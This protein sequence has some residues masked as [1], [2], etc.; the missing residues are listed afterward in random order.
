MKDITNNEM[1]FI[2]T[3]FKNPKT[4][5]NANN[6]SKVLGISSMGCLNIA[7]KLEKEKIISFRQLGKAKFFSIE[8][9]KDYVKDYISFLLKREAEQSIPY[10]RVW[11]NDLR[12]KITRAEIIILFGSVL[13]KWDNAN[14]ID[15]LLVTKQKDFEK[16]KK[17]VENINL[18]SNKKLH[19]VYQTL[20][21]LKE[22]IKKQ[23]PVILNIIRGIVVQGSEKLVE[24]MIKESNGE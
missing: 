17:E 21:D 2:L 23:D 6:L 8:P 22:N 1:R 14:D 18:I 24:V 11:I 16:L 7:K 4:K 5:Y 10:I 19:P 15:V 13:T 9:E 12:K 20:Q 3:V